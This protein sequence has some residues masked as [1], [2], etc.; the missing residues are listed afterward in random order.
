MIASRKVFRGSNN[1]ALI[2]AQ[3]GLGLPR[4][5]NARPAHIMRP[6]AAGEGAI[7][8]VTM[9]PFDGISQVSGELAQIAKAPGTE[10]YCRKLYADECEAAVNRQINI[11]YSI[12]YLYHSMFS[13]FDRDNVGL[14]GFA[15][16]FKHESEEERSHAEKL[17]E[18]QTLRGGRVVLGSL[19]S[20]ISEFDNS[21]KGEALYS[22]E[23]ALALEKMNYEK[24]LELHAVASK[25]E[26]PQLCDFVESEYLQ[27]QVEAIKELGVFVSQLRRVGKGHGV[28]HFDRELGSKMN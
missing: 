19:M 26:D 12:S 3:Y 25:N 16:Y 24:L 6:K 9:E 28:Y 2:N 11:E 1:R 14:P 13:F 20:P 15:E 4:V 21:E 23:L 17:M 18:Y 22:M 8:G 27:E 10:S 7:T 5:H